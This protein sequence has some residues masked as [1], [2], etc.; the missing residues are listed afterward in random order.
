MNQG[1][2]SACPDGYTCVLAFSAWEM[3]C[4]SD[5]KCVY[6]GRGVGV[7]DKAAGAR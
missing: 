3:S 4:M 1:S 2:F 5:F 7:N 6:F